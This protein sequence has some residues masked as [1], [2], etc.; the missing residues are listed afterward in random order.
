MFRTDERAPLLGSVRELDKPAQRD[1]SEGVLHLG[2]LETPTG[3]ARGA[4]EGE[5]RYC[6]G[7]FARRLTQEKQAEW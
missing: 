3:E 7:D 5:G 6:G 1:Q 2:A 4:R